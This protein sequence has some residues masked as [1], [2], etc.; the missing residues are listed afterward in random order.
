MV[1]SLGDFLLQNEDL[2]QTDESFR[3]DLTH[4]S[5][6][7]RTLTAGGKRRVKQAAKDSTDINV[8]IRKW[9]KNGTPPIASG[10][11]PSYGD[12]SQGVDYHTAL[13]TLIDA[14]EQFMQLPAPVRTFCDND[15]GLFLDL[16]SDPLNRAK[17]LELGLVEERLPPIVRVETA[18][19]PP[20]PSGGGA[21]DGQNPA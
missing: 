11:E 15:P 4:R 17:L 3:A 6:A 2:M 9:I 18:P 10:R 5:R 13:N 21:P 1:T 16:C 8:M 7:A 14:Q 20:A 12:F 19:V